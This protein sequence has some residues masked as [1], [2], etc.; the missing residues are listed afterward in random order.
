MAKLA[1]HKKQNHKTE[2][3]GADT[4][5][6]IMEYVITITCGAMFILIPL[7][8][9][10]KFYQIGAAKYDLYKGIVLPGLGIMT[11]LCVLYLILGRK[12]INLSWLKKNLSSLDIMVLLYL[13]CV[14]VSF[15]LCDYKSYAIWGYEGW[16]MGLVSQ[17]T[18]VGLYFYVSRFCK[19]GKALLVVL[20]CT[21]VIVFILGI[22]NRFLIDP[23]EVYVGLSDR[24][25]L[26]FLSTLGQSSWYSSFMCV[27]LP[28]GLYFYWDAENRIIRCISGLYCLIGFGTLVTQNSDS[29]YIALLSMMLVFFWFSVQDCNKL[30]C[31]FSITL[32]FLIATRLIKFLTLFGDVRIMDQLDTL[33]L[34]LIKN[35]SI[36][37]FIFMNVLV[38]AIIQ[39][40]HRKDKYNR[41]VMIAVRNVLYVILVVGII[42]GITCLWMSG[43]GNMPESVSKITGKIPY[44][45]WDD[46]WG[47]RRGFT[48]RVTWK[49]FSEMNLK[50]KL[51]GVGPEC[52]SQYAYGR[53]KEQLDETFSG[54]VLSNAHNEWY[55][56]MINYGILG[57]VSYLGLFIM[58]IKRFA[59][60]SQVLILIGITA[61]VA[62]Y[63]GHNAFCYQQVLCT[64]F[65]MCI[66]G[67]GENTI[68]QY[69]N[70]STY[71][72]RK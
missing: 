44:L 36:W 17:L 60:E 67:F 20:C 32:L 22:L 10:N 33:S 8:M 69:G 45:T 66:M 34:V 9:K 4:V 30:F 49:I 6:S 15:V 51:I 25:I 18:F 24:Y 31:F 19:D 14:L 28:I 38:L 2:I 7:Y 16:N 54:L 42:L 63:V 41:K 27:V 29:A 26:E 62:A 71:D 68:R 13:L 1:D 3:T 55:N 64:P 40:L 50:D 56:A 58:A 21:S 72:G 57:A 37:F 35:Q 43:T 46:E 61:C 5:A 70:E 11:A 59:H 53:Y 65:I 12:N 47:N 52:Y 39:T 48:W 23:L